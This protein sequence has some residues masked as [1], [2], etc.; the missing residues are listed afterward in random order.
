MALRFALI[1]TTNTRLW[2]VGW[3]DLTRFRVDGPLHERADGGSILAEFLRDPIAQRCFCTSP[4]PWGNSGEL[5]GPFPM[6]RLVPDWYHRVSIDE[7]RHRVA[8]ALNDPQFR[9]PP[10]EQQSAPVKAWIEA[11]QVRGDDL[12]VLEAPAAP[13]NRVEWDVW[14]VFEEFVSMTRNQDELT[15]VVIGYD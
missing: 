9:E 3:F 6:T 5:H 10:S 4:D 11:L 15:V 14:S 8:A 2:D 13:G 1:E 7:L 12:F